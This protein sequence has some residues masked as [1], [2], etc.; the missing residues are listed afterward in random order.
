MSKKTKVEQNK[1]DGTLGPSYTPE[2]GT[3]ISSVIRTLGG[4]KKAAPFAG[5]TDE[6]LA[7]WRDGKTEPKLF[8]FIGLANAA[9][10]S[11]EWL[12]LG[13][14]AMTQG[15][16]TSSESLG[17]VD[18]ELLETIISLLEQRLDQV[19]K[20]LPPDVKATVIKEIYILMSDDE[21]SGAPLDKPLSS[22]ISGMVKVAS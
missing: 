1:K 9:N 11:L 12:A 2:L 7:N 13:Q 16:S 14:G 19:N 3:R 6:T 8:G 21:E 5:V 15:E 18:I 20:R 22:L 17:P 10:V 4:L